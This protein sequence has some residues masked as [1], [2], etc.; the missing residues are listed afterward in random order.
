[1]A[2][3]Q[4]LVTA[5]LGRM[6]AA[7]FS[8]DRV[9]PGRPVRRAGSRGARKA[10]DVRS[11]RAGSG[12][13]LVRAVLVPLCATL[14]LAACSANNEPDG[15]I[16]FERNTEFD[17]ETLRFFLS[18][19]DGTEVS[20]HTADD[21]IGN[22]AAPT[23]LPGQRARALTFHKETDAGTSVA[24]ALLSWNP[25]NLAD[26]LVF[27]WW[28]E[29]PDQHVPDLSFAEVEPFVII[30]G[31]EIDHGI[32]PQVPTDGV[33][34]YTGQAGGLY[35]YTF[36]TDW[37]EDEG[38]FVIDEYQGV[39]TLTADFA[40][41]TVRGCIGCVGDIVTR[42]AHFGVFLGRD[43]I[44]VQGLARD[45]EIHL[46]TA[47]LGEDGQF[48]RDRVT[49]RHPDRA[50]TSSDGIWGGTL[51]SRQDTDGNP[52]L[53]AGVNIVEF[54]EGDGSEG[55][56]VGSLLGLSGTFRQDGMSSLP[57]EDGAPETDR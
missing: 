41:G 52:R 30:D 31:P 5:H 35:D 55:V 24:H 4:A 40:D 34:I 17:G 44:D 53:I 56:F 26:Y 36:G 19:E 10:R 57:P 7:A 32:V 11:P 51:S 9:A 49:V 25:D 47:I 37:G 28:A 54:E 15:I 13:S 2:L 12:A 22:V 23:P 14:A 27:G 6:S 20:V 1:M 39:L 38:E 33:A 29:F 21:L 8:N 50:V 16:S 42:R 48:E 45:Y 3:D 18:L 43:P 46:A